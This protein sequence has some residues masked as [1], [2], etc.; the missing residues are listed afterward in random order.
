[1]NGLGEITRALDAFSAQTAA[2]PAKTTQ[3]LP[4]AVSVSG[5]E[6]T[7]DAA[8][9]TERISISA[10]AVQ[11]LQRERDLEAEQAAA[12]RAANEDA[13]LAARMAHEMAYRREVVV[14]PPASYTKLPNTVYS[15]GASTVGNSAGI[16]RAQSDLD[17]ARLAR[18]AFYELEK[19]KGTPPAEIYARLAAL[20]AARASGHSIA[21]AA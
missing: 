19:S 4:P 12:Q 5:K 16:A 2:T 21:L 6:R 3:S 18:I 8:V 20:N 15:G 10:E 9:A 1:M 11:Q 14:V 17:Q 13:E 7:P